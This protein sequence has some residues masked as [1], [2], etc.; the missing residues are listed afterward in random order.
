MLLIGCFRPLQEGPSAQHSHSWGALEVVFKKIRPNS[1]S[2][3]S[4]HCVSGVGRTN[5][6]GDLTEAVSHRCLH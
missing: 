4:L 5:R 3:D 2:A 1:H 6:L